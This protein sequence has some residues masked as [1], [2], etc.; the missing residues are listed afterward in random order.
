ME[1]VRLDLAMKKKQAAT[2]EELTLS[3][4]AVNNM[5]RTLRKSGN[6]NTAS[7]SNSNEGN[8]NNVEKS[9]LYLEPLDQRALKVEIA[10]AEVTRATHY[11]AC[12]RLRRSGA[13]F[14]ARRQRLEATLAYL[15]SGVRG[16][17][18]SLERVMGQLRKQL[19]LSRIQERVFR[20]EV[21]K[22]DKKGLKT[23]RHLAEVKAQL[24]TLELQPHKVGSAECIVR[25]HASF[26]TANAPSRGTVF[27]HI[28][29]ARHM[30]RASSGAGPV[31]TLASSHSNYVHLERLPP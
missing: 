15:T 12:R 7:N 9:M 5:T 16:T 25:L 31:N 27:P 14:N 4:R 3:I 22:A 21:D 23:R 28:V 26:R 29:K 30:P 20:D 11:N 10:A 6:Q 8:D 24:G 18:L 17:L 1:A 13:V 2:R 19:A